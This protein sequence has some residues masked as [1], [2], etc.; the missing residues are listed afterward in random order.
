MNMISASP[1]EI[2]SICG[3]NSEIKILCNGQIEQL[4]EIPTQLNVSIVVPDGITNITTS[5]FTLQVKI[6]NDIGFCNYSLNNGT[7]TT[8]NGVDYTFSAP[9]SVSDGNNF[10]N[11]WC[12]DTFNLNNSYHKYLLFSVKIAT[13]G[14][15]S[16]GGSTPI[17][18]YK[19]A[20][21]G[22]SWKFNELNNVDV[23]VY[24]ILDN[25]IDPDSI[26]ITIIDNISIN[27]QSIIRKNQGKYRGIFNIS[28]SNLKSI[29]LN[30][31]AKESLKVVSE[32][33]VV[34]TE[35]ISTFEELQN[36]TTQSLGKVSSVWKKYWLYIILFLLFLLIIVLFCIFFW[37]GKDRED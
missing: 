35:K 27:S 26:N 29:R 23:Y 5:P 30:I 2:R 25:L 14:G 18:L 19:I 21:F 7:N 12:R 22:E 4:Y 31:T 32:E 9:L 28:K 37:F 34:F 13:Q 16:S 36:F 20:I 24:E 17:K 6:N 1:E 15:G 8:M 11:I 3:G 10:V 33:F